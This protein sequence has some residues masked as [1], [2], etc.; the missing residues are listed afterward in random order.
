MGR[1]KTDRL[2]GPVRHL[3]QPGVLLVLALTAWNPSYGVMPGETGT[4]HT[5]TAAGLTVNVDT[6]WL[7]GSGYRPVQVTVTPA[8][9]SS[10]DRTLTV[11]IL[12]HQAYSSSPHH[13]LRVTQEI[14]IP[15][16]SGAI[17]ATLAVPETF[18]WGSY[19]IHVLEN[20]RV[21]NLQPF[22][23]SFNSVPW[24][25]LQDAF[26][27]VLVVGTNLPDTTQLAQAWPQ[28]VFNQY[29][30]ASTTSTPGNTPLQ[31]PLPTA[32]ARPASSLPSRW[33]EYS[34]L[35][36]VCLS[37]DELASLKTQ[38]GESFDALLAWTAAGGNLWVY[39]VGGGWPRLPKLESL[40]DFPLPTDDADKSPTGRG[41]REP[42][43]S[44]YNRP[45][46][47]L[48]GFSPAAEV[49]ANSPTAIP[50]IPV[51][52]PFIFREY[53][54]GLIVALAPADPF[55]GTTATWQWLLNSTGTQRWLSYQRHGLSNFREN[56]DFWNF[57][58]PGIGLAPVTAFIVLISLFALVIGPVNYLLLRRWKRLHLML[59]TTPAAAIVVTLALFAY[60][61]VADG[62]GTRVRL[63]SVTRLDQRRGHTVCWARHSYYAGLAPSAGMRFPYDVAV[64]PLEYQPM[65]SGGR[66][67]ELLLD[68]DQWLASGWL[69]SRRPT[70]Y[71][72]I[73]SRASSH[74]L[75]LGEPADEAGPL[76]VTNR[77]GTRI[78][79]LLIHAKDGRFYWASDVAA[80][81]TAQAEPVDPLVASQRLQKTFLAHQPAFLPG[82]DQQSQQSTRYRRG[83]FWWVN[84]GNLSE[85]TQNTSM[86]EAALAQ[87]HASAATD[88]P[89]FQPGSYLA[90]VQRSPEVEL[91]TSVAQEQASFHVILGTW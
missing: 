45:L 16:G 59:L 87:P 4:G 71:L 63:R 51:P 74:R 9:P 28:E 32:M 23:H 14:D 35:D 31:H 17:Q 67:A 22:S 43:K 79:Q 56:G 52:P 82:M 27:R 75:E 8:A 29:G 34:S 77:L 85:P 55:P 24:Q 26:S 7:Q 40:V 78:E 12:L 86:L 13:K 57:L 60:A 18:P 69:T 84:Q 50:S 73:R 47:M 54:M 68:Q 81:G 80:D 19:S 39:G 41:W 5:V 58:I 1:T 11:E 3:W 37:I 25:A 44:L 88:D 76:S 21:L 91:G 70:Q 72:T 30:F 48:A 53:G 66:Q 90:V 89:R 38:R 64:L 83:R 6:T 61:I 62:L 20:G 42:D 10:V 2:T 65:E 15:A 49:L 36:I 46:R 33:I